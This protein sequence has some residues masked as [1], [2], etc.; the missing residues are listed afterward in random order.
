MD[1][2]LD[3]LNENY[4]ILVPILWIIGYA[5]KQTPKVPD[6]LIIWILLGLSILL[7]TIAY[8]FS[9]DAISNGI[10]ATGV[11]VLGHQLLKQTINKD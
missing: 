2:I 9:F 8:G 3:Y 1:W 6:W 10:L 4:Y 7:G 11:S 5:L